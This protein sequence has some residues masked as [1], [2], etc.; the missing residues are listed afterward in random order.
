MLIVREDWVREIIAGTLSTTRLETVIRT[1]KIVGVYALLI[2]SLK[3][4]LGHGPTRSFGGQ[5][6]S[7]VAAF[8]AASW[9]HWGKALG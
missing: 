8:T 4:G 5:I 3:R 2:E 1:P 9:G 6:W 7:S